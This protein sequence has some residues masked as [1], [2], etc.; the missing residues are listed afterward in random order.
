MTPNLDQY[1]VTVHLKPG[2]SIEKCIRKFEATNMQVVEVIRPRA[3]KLSKTNLTFYLKVT[4][5]M[6]R[7]IPKKIEND[8]EEYRTSHYYLLKCST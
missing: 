5:S 3:G 8:G 4:D 2:A 6:A 7:G 1:G